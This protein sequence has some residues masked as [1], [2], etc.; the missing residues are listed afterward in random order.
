MAQSFVEVHYDS[1]EGLTLRLRPLGL[2]LIPE[3]SRQHIRS[4]SK[5]LL[6]VLR[7]FVDRAIEMVEESGDGKARRRRRVD[8]EG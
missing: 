8:I 3:P 1:K 4:A 6:L 5:E 7:S 2:R